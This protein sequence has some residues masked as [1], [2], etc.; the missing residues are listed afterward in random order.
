MNL[1]ETTHGLVQST[2]SLA[3]QLVSTN[4]HTLGTNPLTGVA[5]KLFSILNQL[6]KNIQAYQPDVLHQYLAQEIKQFG[7]QS[8]N[9]GYKDD[10]I[11]VSQYILCYTFDNTIIHSSWGQQ[12]KW[13]N[14]SLTNMLPHS[15][16][17][18]QNFKVALKKMCQLP[19]VFIDIL[20]LIYICLNL[21]HTTEHS[22]FNQ[23][24]QSQDNLSALYSVISLQRGEFEKRLSK[25]APTFPKII[26]KKS[27][28]NLG[29]LFMFGSI[30]IMIGMYVG[31]S[32]LT[33]QASQPI[34]K[35]LNSI[36]RT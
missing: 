4:P 19:D 20:E 13:Q 34:L 33:D 6:K 29:F 36:A 32:Y 11:L 14:F 22:T 5:A 10:H 35:E 23:G 3:T 8:K 16:S 17:I 7:E 21:T 24:W 18:E 1:I 26:R 30:L 27:K 12:H 2:S 9:M 28:K 31:V 15:H 25:P